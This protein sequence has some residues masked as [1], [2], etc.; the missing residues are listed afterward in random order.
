MTV[1][2]ISFTSLLAVS[3]QLCPCTCPPRCSEMTWSACAGP[4]HCCCC[5]KSNYFT[6]NVKV[7]FRP[8]PCEQNRW[9][10]AYFHTAG[11]AWRHSAIETRPVRCRSKKRRRNRW[12]S[13][14]RPK[15]KVW[16]SNFNLTA[17]YCI[18]RQLWTL[19]VK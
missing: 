19:R 13:Q 4:S 14:I 2:F 6:T 3:R 18:C 12:C 10:D 5:I 11:V 16:C 9:F 17:P 1:Y 7:W 8:W 15:M